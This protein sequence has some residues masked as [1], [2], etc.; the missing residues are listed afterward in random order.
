MLKTGTATPKIV[1]VLKPDNEPAVIRDKDT[2]RMDRRE[3]NA[4]E[5]RMMHGEREVYFLAY[6]DEDY[7]KWVLAHRM[8]VYDW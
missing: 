1:K 4:H 6:Y 5:T 2:W 7:G 8:P 3:L